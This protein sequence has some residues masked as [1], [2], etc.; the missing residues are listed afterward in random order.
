[1][2]K[3]IQWF[4]LTYRNGLPDVIISMC[5]AKTLNQAWS[6]TLEKWDRIMEGFRSL[7]DAGTCGLC[8]IYLA[9]LC[10]KCPIQKITGRA[11]C[12]GT[13]YEI[14]AKLREDEANF[15]KAVYLATRKK[16]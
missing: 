15:L 2:K 14:I 9:G 4:E 5:R 16:R 11:H 13:P 1:M 7:S 6:K 10:P 12:N 8:D 3:K